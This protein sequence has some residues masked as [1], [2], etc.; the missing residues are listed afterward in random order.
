VQVG[1]G[2]VG[3]DHEISEMLAVDL[4]A[5][6]VWRLGELHLSQ[7]QRGQKKD[8]KNSFHHGK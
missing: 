1:L 7:A 2:V 6:A 4:N 5:D 3:T 8:S